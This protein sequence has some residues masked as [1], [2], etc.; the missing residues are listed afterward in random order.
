MFLGKTMLTVPLS[1]G[2]H[3]CINV[4]DKFNAEGISFSETRHTP[5]HFRLQKLRTSVCLMDSLACLLADFNLTLHLFRT[6]A[7][8]NYSLFPLR[9]KVHL[10]PKYFFWLK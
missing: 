6:P 10:T 9:V 4:G 5:S 3:R 2:S 7:I 1:T 8:L